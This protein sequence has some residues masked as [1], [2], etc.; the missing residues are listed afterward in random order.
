MGAA[1]DKEKLSQNDSQSKLSSTIQREYTNASNPS[2]ITTSCFWRG[3]AES[4]LG[5]STIAHS[6]THFCATG[7]VLNCV[8]DQNPG[9]G[10]RS[11]DTDL[12]EKK[13]LEACLTELAGA[14]SYRLFLV[15]ECQ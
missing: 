5:L 13:R 10:I 2:V 11:T 1:F 12:N 8:G 4:L 6:G 7:R 14:T 15:G 9:I 3:S